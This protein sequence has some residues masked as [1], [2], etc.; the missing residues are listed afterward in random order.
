MSCT[1]ATAGVIVASTSG[2]GAITT[3]SKKPAKKVIGFRDIFGGGQPEEDSD[4]EVP[5]QN[6]CID[7]GDGAGA[8]V[9]IKVQ[10]SSPIPI[11]SA[12]SAASAHPTL[13]VWGEQFTGDGAISDCEKSP[14]VCGTF[15]AVAS[16]RY[17]SHKMSKHAYLATR[18]SFHFH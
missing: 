6:T 1:T 7:R 5:D 11:A 10:A 4:E 9:G 17:K 8:L 13:V 12:L 3:D 16:P 14:G 15:T 2:L 18:N